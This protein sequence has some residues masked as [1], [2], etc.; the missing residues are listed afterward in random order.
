MWNRDGHLTIWSSSQ[1][2]F[3]VR[4]QTALLLGV[5]VSKVKAIPMVAGAWGKLVVYMEPIAAALA[6]KAGRPVKVTMTRTEVFEG[7]GPA[8]GT[9]IRVKLGATQAGRLVAAEAHLIYE[10]GAFPGSPVSAA[11]QC[12]FAPYD[13]PNAYLEGY[14]V[15]VNRPK[16][17]AYRAPGAPAAAFAMETAIDELCEKLGMDPLDFRLLNSAKEGT[18]RATGPVFPRVGF[19]E[20]LQAAQQHPHYTAPLHGPYRGRG[21]AS[22]FWFTAVGQ[23]APWRW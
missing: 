13:I 19:I 12:M 14:D 3:T 23:R 8:S 22:G 16:S 1:G 20:T 17:A 10:A 15:V 6:K 9:Q 11:C 5:P 7:T 18:R 4:E 21:V 2:H